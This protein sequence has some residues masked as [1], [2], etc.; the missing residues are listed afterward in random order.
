MGPNIQRVPPVALILFSINIHILLYLLENKVYGVWQKAEYVSIQYIYICILGFW[1]C[2]LLYLQGP[3]TYTIA[4][5]SEIN[6][7]FAFWYKCWY[8][9][10]IFSVYPVWK[11]FY[12]PSVYILY[13]AWV[14]SYTKNRIL[15][16]MIY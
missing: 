15:V 3:S 11:I 8:N 6:N 7:I 12:F 2:S 16:L 9:I 1:Y 4:W 5:N 10:L 14:I 13:L